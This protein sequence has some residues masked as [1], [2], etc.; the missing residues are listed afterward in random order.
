MCLDGDRLG[1]DRSNENTGEETFTFFYPIFS[2]CTVK[3]QYSV[4]KK[5]LISAVVIVFW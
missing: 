5:S 1:R 4:K 3:V 2:K